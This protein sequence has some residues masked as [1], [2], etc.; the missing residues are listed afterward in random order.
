MDNNIFCRTCLSPKVD[1]NIR[2]LCIAVE[3]QQTISSTDVLLFCVDIKV[4][5]DSTVSTKLCEK[6][7]QMIV[8]IYIFKSKVIK[9]NEYLNSLILN[10]TLP[11][12]NKNSD[13]DYTC[14]DLTYNDDV[15]IDNNDDTDVEIKIEPEVKEEYVTDNKSEDEILSAIL[16][17]K[18][19]YDA[20]EDSKENVSLNKIKTENRKNKSRKIVKQKHH[21]C[22]ECGKTVLNLKQH[23]KSH[24][25]TK[26]RKEYKCEICNITFSTNMAK[27]K[28]VRSKHKIKRTCTICKKEDECMTKND[29]TC[30]ST[31]QR[32][33]SKCIIYKCIFEVIR[34]RSRINATSAVSTTCRQAV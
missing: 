6:C 13:H 17:N 9:N 20:E 32:V 1:R 23:I 22:E 5:L 3:D 14:N 7:Y 18:L 28:H 12:I 27:R 26:K 8:D 34:R 19:K 4:H 2:D 25:E 10:T 31:V 33:S 29:R 21:V 24:K 16:E 30:V 15:F 11:K